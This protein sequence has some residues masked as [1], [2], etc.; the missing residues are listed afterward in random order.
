MEDNKVNQMVIDRLLKHLECQVD[1]AENGEE[2]LEA[3]SRSQYDLVLMDCMMPVMDG[4]AA[5]SV[6]RNLDGPEARV[7]I[8]ALTA[9]VMLDNQERCLEAG[10]NDVLTKPISR[11]RLIAALVRWGAGRGE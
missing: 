2:C 3:I 6:I 11:D 9:N 5:T 10:M 1:L 8:V 4:Y 7:P